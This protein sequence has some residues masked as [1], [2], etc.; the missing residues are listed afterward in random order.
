MFDYLCLF[1]L[2]IPTT[3][4]R[5]YVLI[6]P[7]IWRQRYWCSGLVLTDVRALAKPSVLVSCV[8]SEKAMTNKEHTNSGNYIWRGEYWNFKCKWWSLTLVWNGL[9]ENYINVKIHK[10]I[11]L[12]IRVKIWHQAHYYDFSLS[13]FMKIYPL[14]FK[15]HLIIALTMY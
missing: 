10:L 2:K 5:S 6:R 8:Y 3:G 9:S 13:I 12:R 15:L 14:D 1:I 7:S 4:M 11:P